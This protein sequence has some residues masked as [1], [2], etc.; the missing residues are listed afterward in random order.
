MFIIID[1][2]VLKGIVSIFVA[3]RNDP[4]LISTLYVCHL[5]MKFIFVKPRI[6]KRINPKKNVAFRSGKNGAWTADSKTRLFK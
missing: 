3:Y 1:S 4:V 5:E 2:I 6:R